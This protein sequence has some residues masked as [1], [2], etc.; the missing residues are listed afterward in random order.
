MEY[1]TIE[2]QFPKLNNSA[3]TLGKFDGIHRGHRKL[4]QKILEQKKETGAAA[5]VLA[6]VSDKKTIYT[7]AE[8]RDL[9]EHMGVDVLLECP[10]N[11]E[12][13]HMKAEQF[14]RQVLVGSLHASYV[15]VGEDFRFGFERKG[16]PEL[17]QKSGN[18]YGFEAE[19]LPKEMDGVRKISSTYIREE[20]NR[21]SMEKVSQLLGCDYFVSGIIE[22]GRGM[23]HREFFPTANLVPMPEKL[24]PP[25]GVYI[26]L[27]GFGQEIY[28]G[29]TNVGYKPTIGETFVG[30]ES[31]LFD[32][33]KNL[34][35]KT[36]TVEFRKFIRKEQK[37][38]SFEALKKQIQEDVKKGRDYFLGN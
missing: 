31:Y 5:V 19:V 30:V 23:G 21:G 14:I 11:S 27:S 20:L 33:E 7:K 4:I 15:A 37:F 38:S 6:F 24:L 18:K 25:N 9:L 1:M 28:P 3:V 26:T 16:T 22:H 8:R 10:L 35:G 17:L 29:I 13:K 2:G 34:Y 12:M 36:C 32:C